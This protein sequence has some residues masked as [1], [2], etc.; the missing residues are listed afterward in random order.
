MAQHSRG[1]NVSRSDNSLFSTREITQQLQPY[2]HTDEQDPR[3]V[4]QADASC[5]RVLVICYRS[6]RYIQRFLCNA[7]SSLCIRWSSSLLSPVMP[8]CFRCKVRGFGPLWSLLASEAGA[9][10]ARVVLD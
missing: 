4:K 7:S 3:V 10:A 9:T 6:L 2:G 5:V 1:L 8:Y